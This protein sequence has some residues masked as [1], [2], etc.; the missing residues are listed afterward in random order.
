[1]EELRFEELGRIRETAEDI[2]QLIQGIARESLKRGKKPELP[3]RFSNLID[4]VID[5]VLND[6]QQRNKLIGVLP[7]YRQEFKAFLIKALSDLASEFKRQKILVDSIFDIKTQE[8]EDRLRLLVE[9]MIINVQEVAYAISKRIPIPQNIFE[10]AKNIARFHN[11]EFINNFL[12]N[13]EYVAKEL[14]IS[15]EEVKESFP[16][17]M[18]L[19]FAAHN[20]SNPLEAL[21]KVKEH[22]EITLS[23]E[24]IAKELGMS[25][26]EVRESFPK[27]M[28]LHFA[29][30]NISNPL[31]ALRK[32][33]EHLEI[34]L[35]DEN[36]A[37]ELGMSIEEVRESFPRSLRLY[38]AVG[39]ISNPLEALRK[40][41][42]HLEITLSD[43]N[44]AKELGMSIEEVRESFPRW[45]RLRLAVDYISNPLEALRKV[46]GHLERTL[47]DENISRELG[48]SIEEVRESFPRWMRLRLAVHNISNPLEALRK[49]KGHLERTLSDENI[50]REL[51]MSIEEVRE[52]FPRWMR[53][54]FAIYYISNPLEALRK[55]K[56]HLEITLSDENIAKELG[57]SI[58]EVR[59]SFPRSLRLYLAVGYISNP[60]EAL[61]KVKEHLEITLSDEN[62]AKELGMS[63]EEVRESFP[64]SL[65]LY[66][67]VGYISNPLEA[68][69]RVKEHLD[70]TLSDENIARELGISLEEV[71]NILPKARKLYF[72][73]HH[74]RN[75]LEGIKDWWE[76][77]IKTPFKIP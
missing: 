43:E 47:S 36:I 1:M 5:D 70:T 66:L 30:H 21:R 13:D 2:L 20:I 22:L 27:W 55:V 19:R 71:K 61:R 3:E 37:K 49:V 74:I 67:A 25:I 39:Y 29:A 73:A 62:I 11:Y 17:G 59:E 58:E 15:V 54:H 52:S 64:R 7:R 41:K 26:E 23:D 8:D 42:G 60:L 56:E 10:N 77:K 46:K 35:S 75:P 32:V 9:M 4:S 76:G 50:S 68:L 51:G 31:E 33:K 24:N 45:M 57:M 38:L 44:I 40:V 53:S 16:Q 65:R 12:N 6:P 69:K 63:I 34:T 72:A 28:R 18:R 14:N 48:M